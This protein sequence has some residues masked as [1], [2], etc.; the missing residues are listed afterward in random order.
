MARTVCSSD[1][2]TSMKR[3][4]TASR[5][6]SS[7]MCIPK[8]SR[9]FGANSNVV[10]MVSIGTVIRNTFSTTL[11]NT[12]LDTRIARAIRRCLSWCCQKV[13]KKVLSRHPI[14]LSRFDL[15]FCL[16]SLSSFHI[17][18]GVGGVGKE[19][20]YIANPVNYIPKIFK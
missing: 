19:H 6:T 10:F 16:Y 4:I 12:P 13:S 18:I 7:A 2:A 20:T 17:N 11:T 8:T 3:S 15:L 5:S 1:A 14:Y 9:T